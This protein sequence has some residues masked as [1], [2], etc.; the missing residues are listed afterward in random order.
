MI[1]VVYIFSLVSF[2]GRPQRCARPF[3]EC[4]NNTKDKDYIVRGTDIFANKRI[5]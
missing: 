2:E 4:V 1:F 3:L 5:I